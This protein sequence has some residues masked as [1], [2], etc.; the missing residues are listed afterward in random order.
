MVCVVH[1]KLNFLSFCVR[2]LPGFS[3]QSNVETKSALACR[4]KLR[5]CARLMHQFDVTI[6]LLL[7]RAAKLTVRE[8]T[9]TDIGNWLNVELPKVQNPRLDLLG[10]AI[11]G[12]LVH[13]ELQSGNDPGMPLRMA[14]YCLG[15]FRL[16]GKFPRQ[17]LLYVGKAPLRMDSQ[18]RSPDLWYRYRAVDVRD[19]DGDRLLE[20]EDIGDNIIAILARVRDDKGAVRKIVRRIADLPASDR[21]TALS[22]LLILAGLRR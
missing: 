15:V 16:Y 18:L 14:E 13:L 17:I 1:L 11:D 3:N 22:Q 20:S 2:F 19:L 7:L 21:D 8:L 12:S 10:E 9:A 5:N 4:A 6:K